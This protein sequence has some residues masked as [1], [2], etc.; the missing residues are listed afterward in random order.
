MAEEHAERCLSDVLGRDLVEVQTDQFGRRYI[1]MLGFGQRDTASKLGF[2]WV[3]F[4]F[5]ILPLEAFLNDPTLNGVLCNKLYNGNARVTLEEID[6][7]DCEYYYS[8][9]DTLEPIP[10]FIRDLEIPDGYYIV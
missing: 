6:V 4:H 2:S 9:A 5:C 3:H 8:D 10:Y 1:W 7:S